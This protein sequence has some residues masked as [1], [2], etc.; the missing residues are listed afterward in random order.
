MV[1]LLLAPI[2]EAFSGAGWAA[3]ILPP[4]ARAIRAEATGG[5]A[6]TA[7]EAVV[8]AAVEIEMVVSAKKQR[9]S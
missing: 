2:P 8:T 1:A 6:V 9:G 4:M 5:E 7:G 3:A